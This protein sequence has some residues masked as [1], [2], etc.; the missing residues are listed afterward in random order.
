MVQYTAAKVSLGIL[1]TLCSKVSLNTT[2]EYDSMDLINMSWFQITLDFLLTVCLN[3]LRFTVIKSD[4]NF[5]HVCPCIYLSLLR[6]LVQFQWRNLKYIF[7]Y[8]PQNQRVLLM[9]VIKC[10]RKVTARIL[11]LAALSQ[12]PL[13]HTWACQM[14]PYAWDCYPT[15][16]GLL[17]KVRIHMLQDAAG[18]TGFQWE[19][20]TKQHSQKMPE[21]HYCYLLSEQ[22]DFEMKAKAG[23]HC[24]I[25]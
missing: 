3:L 4:N 1:F 5:F 10:G 7:I 22:H 18:V 17:G 19:T 16:K 12:S 6:S 9:K 13:P 21:I 25:I 11:K 24:F 14:L 20:G 2:L 15:Q 8:L 23:P